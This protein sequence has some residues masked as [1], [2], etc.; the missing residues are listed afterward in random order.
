[1]GQ[2]GLSLTPEAAPA[3]LA[4]NLFAEVPQA[5]ETISENRILRGGNNVS[6]QPIP[7]AVLS[8]AASSPSVHSGKPEGYPDA[9]FRSPQ[10]K[11][12][13]GSRSPSP[14]KAASA[15]P[16][17]RRPL[18]V[19]GRTD[20]ALSP[21]NSVLSTSMSSARMDLSSSVANSWRKSDAVKSDGGS[22]RA[23]TEQP[24]PAVSRQSP[25]APKP[26][27][28]RS[29]APPPLGSAEFASTVNGNMMPTRL[30]PAKPP[31]RQR[32]LQAAQTSPDFRSQHVDEDSLATESSA[33]RARRAFA[34]SPAG[35]PT[36]Q[37]L[38]WAG[39]TR[40]QAV[41]PLTNVG[42]KG[43]VLKPHH[44]FG[45]KS[46]QSQK[47]FGMT[48]SV[49]ASAI[50]AGPP[51]FVTTDTLPRLPGGKVRKATGPRLF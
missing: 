10:N 27:P 20:P 3:P 22:T 23:P 43:S 29:V 46:P 17:D 6:L 1:V 51:E 24:S 38:A 26:P 37:V 47:G 21:S 28:E 12:N 4:R 45:G 50:D 39:N 40:S 5:P 48:H 8:G 31:S 18:M 30:S 41:L 9:N 11:E 34:D 15:A 49:S 35:N 2:D 19:E 7:Q 33:D 32:G 42:P 36:A 44:G 13:K 25:K 14:G 16:P